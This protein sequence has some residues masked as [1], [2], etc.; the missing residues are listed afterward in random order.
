M[1]QELEIFII[2]HLLDTEVTV[3]QKIQ[4]NFLNN[5]ES[6]PQDLIA[7]VISANKTRKN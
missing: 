3:Y 6:I 5:F 4:S 7:A 1:T 2:I